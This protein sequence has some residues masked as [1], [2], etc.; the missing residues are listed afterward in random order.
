[1][2]W[3]SIARKPFNLI[4]IKTPGDDL[5]LLKSK[6][7]G[8]PYWWSEFPLILNFDPC[9][10]CGQKYTHIGPCEWCYPQNEILRGRMSYHEMPMDQI[11]WILHN[12]NKYGEG[13]REA[14]RRGWGGGSWD[15]FY[16]GDPLA[17]LRLPEILR[18]GKPLG[19]LV[20]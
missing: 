9:N 20:D 11:E 3:R 16:D 12:I 7:L 1:M 10:Y 4:G 15:P 5:D 13:M 14:V 8:K 18:L 17:N 6:L 19:Q 2:K